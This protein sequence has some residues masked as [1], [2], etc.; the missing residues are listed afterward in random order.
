MATTYENVDFSLGY[1]S[2]FCGQAI[3]LSM[4]CELRTLR[5]SA[6][7][8]QITFLLSCSQSLLASPEND[9]KITSFARKVD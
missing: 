8:Y 1:L 2:R 5:K 4:R 7:V 9:L 3:H 6:R